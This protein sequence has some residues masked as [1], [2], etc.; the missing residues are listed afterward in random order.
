MADKNKKSNNFN[1]PLLAVA[2]M[3]D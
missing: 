3:M 2:P 1:M